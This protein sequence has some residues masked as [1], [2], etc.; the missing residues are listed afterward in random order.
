MPSLFG[1]SL[2]RNIDK[3]G[4]RNGLMRKKISIQEGKL[5]I[6]GLMMLGILFIIGAVFSSWWTIKT[7]NEAYVI[8]NSTIIADFNL[9]NAITVTQTDKNSTITMM[10]TIANITNNQATVNRVTSTFG[11]TLIL[12]VAGLALSI[13]AMGLT[14]VSVRKSAFEKYQNIIGLL[15]ALLL[16]IAPLYLAANLNLSDSVISNISPMPTP[17]LWVNLTSS[18]ITNF[19]GS[20]Q[21][22]KSGLYPFWAQGQRFWIWGPSMGWYLAYSGSLLLVID[23]L[24][25]RTKRLDKKFFETRS[26]MPLLL[27]LI[28]AFLIMV[29]CIAIGVNSTPII[30]SFGRIDSTETTWVDNAPLWGRISFGNIDSASGIF[31]AVGIVIASIIIYTTLKLYFKPVHEKIAS[32]VIIFCSALSLF[33]GGGFIIGSILTFVTGILMYETP[34]KFNETFIGKILLA[35]KADS[36]FFRSLTTKTSIKDASRAILFVYLLSGIGNALYTYN[37]EKIIATPSSTIPYEILFS[38]KLFGD[39]MLAL[40]PILTMGLG[41]FKW[42]ILSVLLFFIAK[43]FEFKANLQSITSCV[44]FAYAPICLQLLTP[45]IFTSKPYLATTW[46]FVVL[47]VTNLWVFI[48]LIIGMKNILE[49]SFWKSLAFTLMCVAI[50]MLINYIFSVP[51]EIPYVIKFQIQPQEVVLTA[52]SFLIAISTLFIGKKPS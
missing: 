36:R 4:R 43:I 13:V 29:N 5:I 15:A 52:I 14:I 49:V 42:I 27:M 41:I 2:S 9:F 17:S 39:T 40:T 46:P 33:Y 31:P 6:L 12:I 7:S 20:K 51:L 38:G 19:W 23:F 8:T 47:F 28:G 48:I 24:T 1:Q 44:G 11:V 10:F 50:Y 35:L 25:L 16:I 34:K 45:F 37:V 32:L 26:S 18:E 21:I 22:P 3:N 30:I